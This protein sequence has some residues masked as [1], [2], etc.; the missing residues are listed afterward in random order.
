LQEGTTESRFIVWNMAWKGF[1]EHPVLGWGQES[2][3]Y[4]FNK[5]YNPKL[6]NQEQWFDRTHDCIF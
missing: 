4:V 5:Y 6:Y 2:F 3:N 1:E